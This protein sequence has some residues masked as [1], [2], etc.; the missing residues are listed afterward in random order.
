M[1]LNLPETRLTGMARLPM[2]DPFYFL[3]S[4]LKTLLKPDS[5]APRT[6]G[7]KP[8]SQFGAF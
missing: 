2:P 8:L 3:F 6:S 7:C 5:M 4:L 1:P